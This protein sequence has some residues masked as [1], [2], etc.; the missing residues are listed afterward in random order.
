VRVSE[1]KMCTKDL[2]WSVGM[3][4]DTRGLTGVSIA[5]PRVDGVLQLS[6]PRVYKALRHKKHVSLISG[7]KDVILL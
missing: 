3:V 5:S 7:I 6:N 4:Y 2:C 1:D